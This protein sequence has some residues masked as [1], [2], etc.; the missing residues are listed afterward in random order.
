MKINSSSLKPNLG[1]WNPII[2]PV[3]AAFNHRTAELIRQDRTPRLVD[4]NFAEAESSH[5]ALIMNP[6]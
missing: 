3:L 5:A 4:R 2:D 6:S 1:L